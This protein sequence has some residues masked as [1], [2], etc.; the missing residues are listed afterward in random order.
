MSDNREERYNTKNNARPTAKEI[1]T[2]KNITRL[3]VFT[4]LSVVLYMFAKFPMPGFAPWLDMQ[5]SELPALLAGYMMGPW[6]GAVV[7]VLKCAIKMP[8][9]TTSCVGEIG[10]LLMGIAFVLPAAYIYK[11]NRTLKGALV[12]VSVGIASFAVFSILVNWLVLIPFYARVYDWDMLVGMLKSLFPDITKE[13][14]YVYYLFCSVLPF[15]IIRGIVCGGLTFL[16]YKHL[17]RFFNY[18]F[19]KDGKKTMNDRTVKINS[20]KA[21]ERLGKKLA[22]TLSGG[23]VLL[24]TGE[25]GAGKTVLCKGLA[26][27][28]GV[29]QPVVSPTFTIM[30]E[31]FGEKYKLC[32]FDAYRL[33]DA[34]EAYGAGLTDFIGKDGIICAVEWWENIKELFDGCKTIKITI[35][36]TD[37]GREVGIE[38]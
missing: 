25:L 35:R 19:A 36:K 28:L 31:Y 29:K 18:V 3:A 2:A 16:L 30:N 32:H 11:R 1:F 21:M 27:G 20:P 14:F 10:D 34:D 33:A 7:I 38:K 23:E 8:F 37:K 17:E 22:E 6:Y 26:R 15:N 24:L 9:T 12:S 4:A 5:V 13:T